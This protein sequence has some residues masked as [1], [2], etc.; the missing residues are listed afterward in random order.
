VSKTLTITNTRHPLAFAAGQ[1]AKRAGVRV[2]ASHAVA[3]TDPDGF[4]AIRM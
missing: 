3:N 2:R 1:S 4:F